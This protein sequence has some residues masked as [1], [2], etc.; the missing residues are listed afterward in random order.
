MRLVVEYLPTY[1]KNWGELSKAHPS[2]AGFD[3]RTVEPV[4]ILP[5]NGVAVPLGFKTQFDEGY[6]AQLR[7]RSGLAA[8]YGIGLV[9]GIGTIDAHY[10]GEWKV[11]LY[12]HSNEII[13][14]QRGERVAQVVFNQLPQVDIEIGAVD[15]SD[16]GEGGFGSTGVN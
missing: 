11:L 9:N 3:V 6:E 12:N 5:H 8:R 2:D 16:R 1:D 13:C 14:L 4:T 15:T 7:A 10:R